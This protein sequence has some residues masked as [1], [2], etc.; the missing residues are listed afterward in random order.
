MDYILKNYFEKWV[1]FLLEKEGLV[2]ELPL[3]AGHLSDQ[4]E[5][6]FSLQRVDDTYAD[7]TVI[8][9]MVGFFS[10]IADTDMNGPAMRESEVLVLGELPC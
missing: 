5:D 9:G 10:K 1:L 8:M 4:I 3:V 6:N 2:T 7:D